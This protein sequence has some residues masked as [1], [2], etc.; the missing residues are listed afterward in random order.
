[1]RW[2]HRNNSE[3]KHNKT[4]QKTTQYFFRPGELEDVHALF[5]PKF[6]WFVCGEV[7]H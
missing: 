5:L 1:M 7:G 3:G 4:M 2:R 6:S